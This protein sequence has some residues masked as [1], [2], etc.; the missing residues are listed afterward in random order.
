M[1]K[2]GYLPCKGLVGFKAEEQS[3]S[4]IIA[5]LTPRHQT[6]KNPAGKF[7]CDTP[8]AL[9]KKSQSGGKGSAAAK[10]ILELVKKDHKDTMGDSPTTNSS[11]RRNK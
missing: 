1:S 10:I 11:K 2:I 7:S 5:S 4:G 6:I 9:I 3:L 8:E